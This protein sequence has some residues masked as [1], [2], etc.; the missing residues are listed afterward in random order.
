M[1]S[2]LHDGLCNAWATALGHSW[3]AFSTSGLN[4]TDETLEFLSWGI[5]LPSTP[6]AVSILNT[7]HYSRFAGCLLDSLNLDPDYVFLFD[8]APLNK[9]V[10]AISVFVGSVEISSVR[11][12]WH[13]NLNLIS[14]PNEIIFFSTLTL[15]SHSRKL[16]FGHFECQNNW[17]IT[18]TDGFGGSLLIGAIVA[19]IFRCMKKTKYR[20]GIVSLLLTRIFAR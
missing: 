8:E 19:F 10:Y 9:L 17:M 6:L 7:F 1:W 13:R 18:T 16:R 5:L 12:Q 2:G 11:L 20:V 15:R 4:V 3:N 14:Q